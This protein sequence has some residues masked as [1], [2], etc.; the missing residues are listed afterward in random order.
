MLS[1]S[2]RFVI[3]RHVLSHC[4]TGYISCIHC[5]TDPSELNV[6][7][8]CHIFHWQDVVLTGG[9]S[10]ALDLCICVLAN[11]GQNILV[12]MPGFSIYKT[13]AESHGIL[14]KH[15]N[16]RVLWCSVVSLVYCKFPILRKNLIPQFHC[17]ASNSKNI[18]TQ[19]LIF[20]LV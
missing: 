10:M 6:A 5:H 13:L 7:L 14:V 18:K 4:Y 20:Y 19:T 2:Y 16:L 3:T 11:P 12:P 15:Y 9:C 1:Y 8:S 17:F